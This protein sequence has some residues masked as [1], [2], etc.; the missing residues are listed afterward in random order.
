MSTLGT[1]DSLWRYPVK[2]MRGEEL[3]E[4]FVGFAGIYGDRVFAFKSS[5]APRAFPYLTAREQPQLLQCRPRFR[6]PDR[7]AGPG[8]LAEAEALGSG[9]TP[10]PADPA[11]LL[12]EV[13]TPG[14]RTYAIDDPG[15]VRLLQAGLS[16]PPEVTLVRSDCA[17]TD[18]R[19]VSL[20]PVQ[21]VRQL[22]AEVGSPV[23]RRCFRANVYLDVDGA[24]GFAEERWIGKTLRLGP[25]AVVAVLLRDSR[26]VL[27]TL[28]PDGGAS[29]PEVLRQVARSHGGTIGVYA[30][31][32]VE[33][34]VR[35][36]DAVELVG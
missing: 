6:H 30:A 34:V 1:V 33:G 16:G 26:C 15:L 20:L 3:A 12:V 28:D 24:G 35:K 21:T 11:D 9:V 32:L 8:N 29:R 14:G 27:I 23:D 17:L 19:P 18:C 22:G 13:E 25:K 2:S 5:A 10:A 7:A 36:G 4:V 31:V